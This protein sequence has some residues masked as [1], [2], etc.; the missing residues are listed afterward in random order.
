MMRILTACMVTALAATTLMAQG[1]M[2][3]RDGSRTPSFDEVKAALNLNDSQ[4]AAIQQNNQAAREQ[5]RAIHD[6]SKEKHEA[7]KAEMEAANP[8]P[9]TVGQLM[10]DARASRDQV[11]A[12]HDQTREQNLAVLDETQKTALA[13]LEGERSPALR[14][15]AMLNLIEGRG[16]PGMGRGDGRRGPGMGGPGI[17]GPRQGPRGGGF[18]GGPRS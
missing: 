2:G 6:Q 16:G 12:I 3:P 10:L 18:R 15:A 5:V 13:E 9:T 1:R 17:D 8:N 11:K 7:L 14:Q 4:L